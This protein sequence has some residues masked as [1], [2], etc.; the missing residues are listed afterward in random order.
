MKYENFEEALKRLENLIQQLE[1]GDLPLEQAL[2][3][4]EEGMRLIRF[5]THKLDEVEKKVEILL[6]DEEGR[7]VTQPFVAPAENT[8]D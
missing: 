6:R 1:S 7:L 2:Q 4:F 8:E 3:I 5:C